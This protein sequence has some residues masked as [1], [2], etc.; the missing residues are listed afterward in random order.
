M[1]CAA[2]IDRSTAETEVHVDL[3]LD[4]QGAGVRSTTTYGETFATILQRDTVFGVQF[5]PEK[6]STHGLSMLDGFAAVCLA[7]AAPAAS[8]AGWR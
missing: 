1:T 8:M 4:G 2:Q 3:E 7:H 5:H 6:S